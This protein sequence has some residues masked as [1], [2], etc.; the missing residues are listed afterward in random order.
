[1]GLIYLKEYARVIIIS[2]EFL[3]II[4]AIFFYFNPDYVIPFSSAISE[5]ADLIKHISW[6]PIAMFIWVFKEAKKILSHEEDIEKVMQIWPDY[7]KLKVHFYV[8]LAYSFLFALAGLIVFAMGYTIST[9]KGFV[10]LI[11]P[12][13]GG[14]VV[15]W[16]FFRAQMEQMEIFRISSKS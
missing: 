1:M 2:F 11:S 9:P 10:L 12:V 14:V 7:W 15:V 6:F 8:G 3:L 4:I 13:C 5:N 16:S